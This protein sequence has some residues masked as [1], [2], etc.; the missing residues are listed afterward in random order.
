MLLICLSAELV[1]RIVAK[2]GSEV[3]LMSDVYKLIQQMKSAGGIEEEIPP[4]FALGKII[5]QKV[6][7]LKAKEQDIEIDQDKLRKS[8]EGYLKQIKSRYPSEAQFYSDLSREKLTESDLLDFYIDQLKEKAM[9][10]QLLNRYVYSQIEV[11]EEEMQQFYETSKDSLAVKP[12]TWEVGMILYD[13]KPSDSSE[14]L[15]LAE[16][17]DIQK[18]LNMGEDF[19]ALALETS[20]CP[21]KSEGGDLGFFGRGMMVKPFEDA[22]FALNVGEISDVVRT[23]FGYHIIKVEEKRENE[24]RAR[25]ILKLVVPTSTDSLAAYATME[26]V[27]NLFTTQQKTFAELAQE[28]SLDEETKAKGGIVGDLSEAELPE[29]FAAQIMAAPVGQMTP[30]LEN[31]GMLYLFSRLKESPTRLY[32]YEEVSDKVKEYITVTKQD[33]AYEDWIAKLISE[34]YVQIMEQ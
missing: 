30:V 17:K 11:T 8:A 34:S 22:A 10:D 16:I 2:V 27:R 5:E 9:T 19:A 20:D 18:R 12:I 14:T 25:H 24:I 13:T 33:S 7:L 21:S 32:S 4:M 15:K 23:Q 1:D 29:L 6:I 31:E 28:Y 3:I 26:Q